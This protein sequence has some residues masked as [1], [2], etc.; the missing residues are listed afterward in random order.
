MIPSSWPSDESMSGKPQ[1]YKI[2]YL[3]CCRITWKYGF[4]VGII[5]IY[6]SAVRDVVWFYTHFSLAKHAVLLLQ[7]H[8]NVHWAF[9]FLCVIYS[10]FHVLV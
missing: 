8:R 2:K 6:C 7:P 1:A 5:I 3:N 4:I 9:L 10:Y